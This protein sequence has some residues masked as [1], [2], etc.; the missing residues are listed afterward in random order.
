MLLAEKP[1]FCPFQFQ[2]VLERAEKRGLMT[3]M[4]REDLVD[5]IPSL[6]AEYR[7]SAITQVANNLYE[8]FVKVVYRLNAP[9]I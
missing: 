4:K 6:S 9:T 2:R 8:N 7:L 5:A 3:A 1:N